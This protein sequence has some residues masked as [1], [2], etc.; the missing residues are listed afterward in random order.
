M[1]SSSFV[2]EEAF[3][4]NIGW[5]TRKEQGILSQKRIAIA[6]LGGVGGIHLLALLRLGITK[7]NIADGDHFELA[8][9]NR[10]FGATTSSLGKN[11]LDVMIAMAKDVNP[12]AQ[13]NSFQGNISE[14]NIDA[15]LTGVDLYV[16]SLDFFE[17]DVRALVF[18]K[19]YERNIPAITAG[20]VGIGTALMVFRPGG[21]SFEQYFRL[22][23]VQAK[24]KSIRF[25]IGLTPRLAHTSYLVDPSMVDFNA[26]KVPSLGLS[27]VLCAGF[28]T[29][30]ALKILLGRGKVYTAPYTQQIDA[31]TGRWVRTYMP[32]GNANPLQKIKLFFLKRRLKI[33]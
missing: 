24:E 8:N 14:A 1:Q 12:E 13:I 3:Q 30:E 28:A 17:M 33:G 22:V 27:C 5:V 9:F 31:Y 21:M 32:W 10:Q 16:D 25:L 18:K 2:Y 11:K 6:G 4:R 29:A 19:C 15:F 20:P 26:R 7:F 23:G